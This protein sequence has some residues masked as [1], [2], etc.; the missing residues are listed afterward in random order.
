MER[1]PTE[2]AIT[3]QV[4]AFVGLRLTQAARAQ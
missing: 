3:G 4:G 2:T 1:L